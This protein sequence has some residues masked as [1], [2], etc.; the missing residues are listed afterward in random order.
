MLFGLLP[1]GLKTKPALKPAPEPVVAPPV[2]ST[3]LIKVLQIAAQRVENGWIQGQERDS[4]GNVCAIGAI[5]IGVNLV[6][7]QNSHYWKSMTLSEGLGQ[8]SS[9]RISGG[10]P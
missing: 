7:G 5:L 4:F 1:S 9:M 10:T 8:L 3:P 6:Y 2:I